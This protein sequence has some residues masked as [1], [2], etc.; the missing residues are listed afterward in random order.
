MA[1]RLN[2]RLNHCCFCSLPISQGVFFWCLFDLLALLLSSFFLFHQVVNVSNY[3]HSLPLM[4]IFIGSLLMNLFLLVSIVQGDRRKLLVWQCAIILD[5]LGI[6]SYLLYFQVLL[7]REPQPLRLII[8]FH[9]S[10]CT[11][12]RA[13]F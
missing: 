9:F 5:F 11:L 12:E 4:A 1:L 8:R 2:C 6:L 3:A 10:R 7:K 13:W